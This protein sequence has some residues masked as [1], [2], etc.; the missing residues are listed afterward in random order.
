MRKII[1]EVDA[2]LIP[3]LVQYLQ[4][5]AQHRPFGEV[6]GFVNRLSQA[7]EVQPE[8]KGMD[9]APELTPDVPL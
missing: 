8:A 5:V 6:A 3:E 1:V 2:D 9:P 7:R 4:Q